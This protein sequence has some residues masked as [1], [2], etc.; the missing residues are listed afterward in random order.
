MGDRQSVLSRRKVVAGAGTVGA[1]AAAATAL[2][3]LKDGAQNVVQAAQT[4]SPA[5]SGYRE[6][7]HVLQYYSTTRI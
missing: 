7:A 1:L 6:T 4:N 3:A 5:G 2:P